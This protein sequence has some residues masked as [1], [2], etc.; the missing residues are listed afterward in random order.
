MLESGLRA[1]E[2]LI[3]ARAK[4][5]PGEWK[6]SVKENLPF[7]IR[8]A[9]KY[10]QLYQLREEA[11]ILVE[12]AGANS[13]FALNSL[14]E[15]QKRINVRSV[16]VPATLPNMEP[17]TGHFEVK[18]SDTTPVQP[19]HATPPPVTPGKEGVEDEADAPEDEE[20][21]EI[22]TPEEEDEDDGEEASEEEDTT[23]DPEGEDDDDSGEEWKGRRKNRPEQVVIRRY[24]P[25]MRT[26]GQL[27]GMLDERLWDELV[28]AIVGLKATRPDRR[29]Y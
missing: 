13:E 5:K 20:E 4:V 12:E 16:C 2:K 8:Q 14:G 24:E 18:Q 6:K 1:G 27:Y 7:G 22:D 15:V 11:K 19:R 10:I 3:K 23:G 21:D 25:P 26:A 17:W 9:Q 29:D 28:L